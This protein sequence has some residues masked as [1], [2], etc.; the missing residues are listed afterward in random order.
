MISGSMRKM[1]FFLFCFEKLM[2]F[3]NKKF[4][5]LKI[6]HYLLLILLLLKIWHREQKFSCKKKTLIHQKHQRKMYI[7][8]SMSFLSATNWFFL[9]HCSIWFA[10]FTLQS[11]YYCSSSS[12]I[13]SWSNMIWYGKKKNIWWWQCSALFFFS[14]SKTIFV[15]PNMP[16][17]Q[18][19]FS[20][21]WISIFGVSWIWI[22]R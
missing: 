9:F 11:Y 16:L 3:W 17:R 1:S 20:Y 5:K 2:K 13:I 10:M 19:N 15:H 21:H 18:W 22:Y 7:S 8:M 14:L 12:K 6:N 4:D